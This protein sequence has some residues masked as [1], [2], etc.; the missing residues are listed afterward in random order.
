MVPSEGDVNSR[1]FASKSQAPGGLGFNFLSFDD[2]LGMKSAQKAEDEDERF[3]RTM[4]VYESKVRKEEERMK[5]EKARMDFT[6]QVLMGGRE[7][8]RTSVV[9]IKK[10]LEGGGGV[11][12][13]ER[14]EPDLDQMI[15]WQLLHVGICERIKDNMESLPNL[16]G[17]RG[18]GRYAKRQPPELIELGNQ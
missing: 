12:K 14:G 1:Y 13:G 6:Q 15:E 9:E 17:V 5:K 16:N 11:G 4:E 3:R 2:V 18:P 10:I 8:R 7:R